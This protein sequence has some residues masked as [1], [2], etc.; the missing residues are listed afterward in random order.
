MTAIVLRRFG[1]AILARV[2][3]P[4][5]LQISLIGFGIIMPKNMWKVNPALRRDTIDA[6]HPPDTSQRRYW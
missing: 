5:A 4:V 6:Q 3:E 1:A 2:Q